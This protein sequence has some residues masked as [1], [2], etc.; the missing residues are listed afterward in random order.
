MTSRNAPGRQGVGVRLWP[1]AWKVRQATTVE[2]R[3]G[4]EKGKTQQGKQ[5]GDAQEGEGGEEGVGGVAS[6]LV[7]EFFL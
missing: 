7:G 6:A 1:T 2:R 3:G 4:A 5:K